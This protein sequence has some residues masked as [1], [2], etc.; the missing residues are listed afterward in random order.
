M[1]QGGSG[2]HSRPT[3]QCRFLC[4]R[5]EMTVGSLIRVYFNLRLPYK[6]ITLL[7][8]RH[9][10]LSSV[11][12]QEILQFWEG[13]YFY[14]WTITNIWPTSWVWVD[15]HKK[16]NGLVVR[17]EDV[18]LILKELDPRVLNSEHRDVSIAE[19]ILPK[20]Q[21][22]FGTYGAFP[23][24]RGGRFKRAVTSAARLWLRF[25]LA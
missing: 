13:N 16:E 21:I 19:A 15:V 14:L 3:F 20:D 11:P 9:H 1:R 25:H 6:D 24:Q 2:A 5:F 12:A 23:L 8:A 10:V 18:R 17:K 4:I 7:L 22:I